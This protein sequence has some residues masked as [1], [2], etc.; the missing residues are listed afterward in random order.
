MRS[1]RGGAHWYRDLIERVGRS[2]AGDKARPA[3]LPPAIIADLHESRR[4]RHLANHNYNT[5][6]LAKAAP[7]IDAARR[8]AAALPTAVQAFQAVIDPAD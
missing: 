8:L 3:I 6:D 4:F 7:S 1:P 5:F 2:P